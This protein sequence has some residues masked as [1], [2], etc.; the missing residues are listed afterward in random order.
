MEKNK[1]NNKK[2]IIENFQIL[3]MMKIMKNQMMMINF[4]DNFQMKKI[5][6]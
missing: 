4:I 3:Q 1:K 2:N 6:H 5:Q